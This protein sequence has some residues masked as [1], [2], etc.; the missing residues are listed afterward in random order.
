MSRSIHRIAACVLPPLLVVLAWGRPAGAQ[1]SETVFTYQG[2]L[3]QS[4][5]PFSGDASMRFSL[6]DALTGGNLVGGVI[7]IIAPVS[8][9]L[10]TAQLDFGTGILP[11]LEQQPLWL[12]VE[13][14]GR[15]LSPRQAVTAAPR[16]LHAT[17]AREA[18]NRFNI[19][20][21]AGTLNFA[22]G[23]IGIDPDMQGFV[24]NWRDVTIHDPDLNAPKS[25]HFGAG[26]GN[27]SLIHDPDLR[28]FIICHPDVFVG[29]PQLN[30][31]KTLRFGAAAG[32]PS[33]GF[34]PAVG[35]IIIQNG[36]VFVGDPQLSSPKVL[37]L[38][39][40]VGDPCIAL[41]P[42][43]GP[44]LLLGGREVYLGGPDTVTPKLHL[45]G[46]G[47]PEIR[48]ERGDGSVVIGSNTVVVGDPQISQ[49][50]VLRFGTDPRDP[51]PFI[52]T[53]V[54]DPEIL[55]LNASSA[56]RLDGSFVGIGLAS[57]A[58][59]QFRVDLPNVAGPGGQ[60][61]ANAWTTYSS[62]RWKEN[63]RPIDGALEKI[64]ALEGVY[65]DWKREQGG[66]A[67]I[68]LVAEDVGKVLPELVEWEE[69]GVAARS[70]KYDRLTAIAIEGI[71]AQQREIEE[72]RAQNLALAARLAAI[73]DRLAELGERH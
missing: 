18:A 39:R 6:H 45:G 61:R 72:L 16:A 62:R 17:R 20:G 51:P 52:G 26:A 22:T 40:G 67:D 43:V 46:V 58:A 44:G 41:D 38:G 60:G 21:D 23:G 70:L 8:D 12:Q 3:M 34:D 32:G 59:P 55:V 48:Y 1:V 47:D 56:I 33:I 42:A 57:T 13:V 35:G 11:Y 63:I 31:A 24:I 64:A 9:G 15:A 4:G 68:G 14:N 37:H 49:A 27:P 36:D 53:S 19:T 5:Q 2:R 69:D 25:L 54:S 10:V 50:K 71:K 29:D 66:G 30:T 73:E 65:F 7:A 28:G